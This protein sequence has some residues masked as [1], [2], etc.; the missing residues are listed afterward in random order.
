MTRREMA[1][2]I[3][4]LAATVPPSALPELYV[5]IE[6]GV[7]RIRTENEL[8]SFPKAYLMPL[9]AKCATESERGKVDE[10]EDGLFPDYHVSGSDVIETISVEDTLEQDHSDLTQTE[11]QWELLP[12]DWE[13]FNAETRRLIN[14]LPPIPGGF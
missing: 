14:N 6:H 9:L 4:R 12:I 2:Y 13:K 3:L 1:G 8:C 11:V 5:H 7:H 10:P